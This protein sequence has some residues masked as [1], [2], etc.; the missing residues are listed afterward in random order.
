VGV[1]SAGASTVC[2]SGS[3]TASFAFKGSPEEWTVPRTVT[4][5]V[6]VVNGAGGGGAPEPGSEG[7]AG[8]RIKATLAVA[9]G[10]KLKL[11][12]GGGGGGG[13]FPGAGGY[14]GG[15]GG[16][17][18]VGYSAAGGG[19]GSFLF[20]ESG[21][22]LIAAGGG[23]GDGGYK[24]TGGNGGHS[25]ASGA[26]NGVAG[27]KGASESA[28]G[29]AGPLG[30]AGTGPT[31]STA[32]QGAGGEGGNGWWGGG[33]GGGGYYGGG[34]GGTTAGL[35]L[36]DGGGGGG[37]STVAGGSSVAYEEGKGGKGGGVGIGVG[38][39]SGAIS[40]TFTQPST[41]AAL[42]TSTSSP[43]V[44]T[45]VTYTATVS[46][47]P[48]SG[49]VAFKEGVSTI[50]GCGARTVSAVTGKVTCEVTYNS[51]S[52]H[53]VKA[54]FSGSED[55]V[56]PAA[57]SSSATVTATASTAT[58]L[59]ASS[60]SPAVGQPVTY[61]AAVSPAPNGGTVAF[62]DEGATISG[63]GAQPVNTSTGKA[64]C[65]VTYEGAG[66]HH[67]KAAFSGSPDN[68]YI[69]SQTASPITVVS[70]QT[71]TTTLSAG[72][73]PTVGQALTY[74]ATVSP[75]P[76]GGT[77]AFKD[78]GATISGCGAQAVNTS[79]GK[80]TCEVTY[81]GVGVHRVKAAFS[82]SPDTSYTASQTIS[83][84]EVT[85]AALTTTAL[86]VPDRQ[87]TLGQAVT[88][89]VTVTP[90]PTSGTVSFADNGVAI[91]GCEAQPVS[92]AGGT[93]VCEVTV[94]QSGSH[95]ISAV[96]SGSSDRLYDSSQ[97]QEPT[98]VVVAAPV[99]SP[100]AEPVAA[101]ASPVTPTTAG[102]APPAVVVFPRA[103][104]SRRT[105]T[106]H[107]AQHLTLPGGAKIKSATV[108]LA[109]RV[110]AR[111][112]GS[113]PVAEISLKG[114]AKGALTMRIV[115]VTTTNL[116][117]TAV[118]VLHTCTRAPARRGHRA[119]H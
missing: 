99:V 62:K 56:Y 88:Y 36:E 77:V 7:G 41:T 43:A 57:E 112:T 97:T 105:L 95:S 100:G 119:A 8:A 68:S 21:S 35:S 14:G 40:A 23:G 53:M 32:I 42:E 45:V 9:E 91:G 13:G 69:A 34:G 61:T 114:R 108:L 70:V 87:P 38:G 80:A 79:T 4:S 72:P 47:A 18:G 5:V 31:T 96:F 3:C 92:M 63:C 50:T 82:G 113:R 30:K 27:G 93:A 90:I 106:V 39:T 20:A 83:P 52:V 98:I 107:L 118:V 58:G 104:L 102:G 60:T 12:I 10:E 67:V 54:M 75:T 48:N 111:L 49:T 66:V 103:C 1:G 86:S 110:V 33:G 73:S 116:T 46:P 25:G 71:T 64:T 16:G 89:S 26:S 2:S 84:T 101:T 76:N 81:E 74:A 59:G 24:A 85:A 109:G 115:V 22:L 65:E 28:G 117:R 29:S 94:A 37:S 6:F 19:G 78:E 15:A 55:T 44:G 17:T 11:A 51:P